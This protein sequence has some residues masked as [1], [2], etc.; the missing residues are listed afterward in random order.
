MG[1]ESAGKGGCRVTV[2][3]SGRQTLELNFSQGGSNKGAEGGRAIL[4]QVCVAGNSLQCRVEDGLIPGDGRW[5]P[6]G[7]LSRSLGTVFGHLNLDRQT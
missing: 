5:A 7:S 3:E 2:E 1:E 6:V 4:F